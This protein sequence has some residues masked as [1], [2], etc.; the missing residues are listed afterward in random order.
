M[1]PLAINAQRGNGALGVV[2]N[3]PLAAIGAARSR[4]MPRRRKQCAVTACKNAL[5]DVGGKG[6]IPVK[7]QQCQPGK[8]ARCS[9]EA[10]RRDFVAS[11]I[12]QKMPVLFA[13]GR[14]P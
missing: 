14:M 3:P 13:S 7:D 10:R 9:V 4:G 5:P 1:N 12:D 11:R 2:R 6:R 8:V